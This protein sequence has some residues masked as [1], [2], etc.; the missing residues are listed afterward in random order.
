V[1]KN[2]QLITRQLIGG[3]IAAFFFLANHPASSQ[4]NPNTA[5]LLLFEA[6]K[7]L[8]EN[9]EDP[10][11]SF[12]LAM[13]LQTLGEYQ[14]AIEIFRGLL[15][16]NP[17]EPRPRLELAR[18]LQLSK[19]YE[20]A[21]YH[22]EQVLSD[23]NVPESVKINIQNMISDIRSTK[24]SFTFDFF[25]VS[26]SNPNQATSS[27]TLDIQGLTYSL[28]QS[29]RSQEVAGIKAMINGHIPFSNDSLWFGE[30]QFEHTEYDVSAMNFSTA[31]ASIGRNFLLEPNIFS[32]QA[33]HLTARYGSDPL[34]SGGTYTAAWIRPFSNQLIGSLKGNLRH[35]DYATSYQGYDTKSSSVEASL[36]YILDTTSRCVFQFANI[37][38]HA[39]Y[40]INSYDEKLASVSLHKEFP[41]GWRGE[42]SYTTR[43][44]E[45]NAIDPFFGVTRHD[46]SSH[47]SFTVS[48]TTF[49]F[50]GLTPKLI[51]TQSTGDSTIALHQFS[52]ESLKVGISKVF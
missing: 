50:F 27:P 17:S 31:Q 9:P 26:D 12:V 2:N 25:F 34:F 18:S 33:G 43:E 41:L 7:K 20:E 10:Q 24:P 23:P 30:I 37:N 45:Y 8:L 49:S 28:G 48:N 29:A 22:Y 38:H 32:L 42:V 21:Q 47:I 52:R 4:V 6:K 51:Y 5:A 15:K 3:I 1:L 14:L 40:A 35:L 16:V 11:A 36:I 13:S 39:D 19:Q 46:S 44:A